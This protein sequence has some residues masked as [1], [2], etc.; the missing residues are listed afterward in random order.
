MLQYTY[1]LTYS[2]EQSPW[3][4][5]RFAASQEIPRILWNPKVNY[6]IHKCRHYPEPPQSSPYPHIPLAEDPP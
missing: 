3:E 5:N 6:R 4:G 1:L 2:M